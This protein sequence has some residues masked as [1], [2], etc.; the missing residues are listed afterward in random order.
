MKYRFFSLFMAAVMTLGAMAQ[1]AKSV[2]DKSASV[3]SKGAVALSFTAKGSFGASSGKI[4]VQGNKFVLQSPQ[5]R[6]WFDGKTEWALAQ[7]SDEVNVTT[8][9]AKEIASMNPMNFLYLYKKG[10][11]ATLAEKQQKHEV[12]LV[13]TNPKAAI[14]ELFILIDKTSTYPTH[15]RLRTGDNQ[16]TSIQIG[17]IQQ[18]SKRPEAHF[19]FNAKDYPK[20]EVVD[21]R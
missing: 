6:I 9:S 14:K 17:S 3:L 11:R 8:P 13:A 5:A 20:V 4:T 7:G 2:L 1:T 10:Y 19:R 18:L 12:H 16:W 15:V 21:L